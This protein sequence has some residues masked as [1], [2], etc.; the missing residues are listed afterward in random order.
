MNGSGM[1]QQK[2]KPDRHR[3]PAEDDGPAGG[4]HRGDDGLRLVAPASRSSR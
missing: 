2:R 3:R 4:L 1:R